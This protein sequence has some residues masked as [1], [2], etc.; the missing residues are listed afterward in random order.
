M[1]LLFRKIP[2]GIVKN[3]NMA[4]VWTRSVHLVPFLMGF[5]GLS[6]TPMHWKNSA[7]TIPDNIG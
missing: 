4:T 2:K 1:D 6:S 3:V 7:T 5:T